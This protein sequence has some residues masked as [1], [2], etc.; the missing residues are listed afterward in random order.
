MPQAPLNN[1]NFILQ[2]PTTLNTH[3]SNED[4]YSFD[5]LKPQQSKSMSPSQNMDKKSPST[6]VRPPLPPQA[7]DDVYSFD[8][9]APPPQLPKKANSNV[10]EDMHH[11]KYN[12]KPQQQ[13]TDD[14]YTFD[15][16][17]DIDRLQQQRVQRQQKSGYDQV[18]LPVKSTTSSTSSDPQEDYMEP[19]DD[20]QLKFIQ[21]DNQ[22]YNQLSAKVVDQTY[23]RLQDA[24]TQQPPQLPMKK[25]AK[26]GTADVNSPV[27]TAP[28]P[29]LG[30]EGQPYSRREPLSPIRVRILFA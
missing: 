24:V 20:D 1:I 30:H 7:D 27:K 17:N 28:N 22:M 18:S 21:E 5:N 26:S 12:T 6:P 10:K 13:P 4:V 29:P 3:G 11:V 25:K 15:R 8:Q 2:V 14:I 19:L 16:L 9:L 23:D